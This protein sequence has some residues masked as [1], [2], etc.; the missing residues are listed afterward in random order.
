MR[1]N[2]EIVLDEEHTNSY[3]FQIIKGFKDGEVFVLD[4]SKIA[5][6]TSVYHNFLEKKFDVWVHSIKSSANIGTVAYTPRLNCDKQ[7]NCLFENARINFFEFNTDSVMV[8]IGKEKMNGERID[9]LFV[10]QKNN[11]CKDCLYTIIDSWFKES[12]ID[13]ASADGIIVL[14]AIISS[15]KNDSKYIFPPLAELKSSTLIPLE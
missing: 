5:I 11:N 10:V 1:V 6:D 14:S 2:T 7:E 12:S 13:F 15:L 9:R 8:Y 3:L 4:G